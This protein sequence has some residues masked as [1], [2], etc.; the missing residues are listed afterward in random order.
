MAGQV[1]A[2]INDLIFLSKIRETAKQVGVE[3]VTVTDSLSVESISARQP[4]GI[5][6]DLNSGLRASVEWVRTIKADA[7]GRRIPIVAFASHVQSDLIAAA[8][9]AGCDRVLARSA[10]TQQLPA[11]M[12]SWLSSQADTTS[13]ESGGETPK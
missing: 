3:V 5:L 4:R 13:A 12:R 10:F 9:Q 7:A 8:R 6:L 1:L 2:V 11:L